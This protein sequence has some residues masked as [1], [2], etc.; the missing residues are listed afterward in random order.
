MDLQ[1]FHIG[2]K[3]IA[4]LAPVLGGA[5]LSG[6]RIAVDLASGHQLDFFEPAYVLENS[7]YAAAGAILSSALFGA[8]Y[9]IL[10]ARAAE[11]S[12]LQLPWSPANGTPATRRAKLDAAES[13]NRLFHIAEST[14]DKGL[15]QEVAAR[16]VHSQ[17]EE[18]GDNLKRFGRMQFITPNPRNAALRHSNSLASKAIRSDGYDLIVASARAGDSVEATDFQNSIYWWLNPRVAHAFFDYNLSIL[19][20]GAT[21]TRIFGCHHPQWREDED[22]AKRALIQLQANIRG[23]DVYTIKYEDF[24]DSRGLEIEAIDHLCLVRNGVPQPG[25]EWAIDKQGDTEK[26][27]FVLGEARLATLHDNFAKLLDSGQRGSH[28]ERMEPRQEYDPNNEADRKRIKDELAK[29]AARC[30]TL[31]AGS[32]VANR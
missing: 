28:L 31:H 3:M 16:L 30:H 24:D 22:G 29:I 4:L 13:M 11:D 5:L 10:A 25:I 19:R 15:A 20:K 26:V 12:Y 7:L 32:D 18:Q 23:L 9:V 27:F 8:R 2:D 17:L 21:I 6:I 14:L 1:R